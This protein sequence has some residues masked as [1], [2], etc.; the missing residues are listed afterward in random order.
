MKTWNE[1]CLELSV[2]CYEVSL[3]TESYNDSLAAVYLSD[4]ST[5]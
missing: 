3:A 1:W 4:H 5:L 2:L